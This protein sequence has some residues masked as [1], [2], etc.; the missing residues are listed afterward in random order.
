MEEAVLAARENAAQNN[1]TNTVFE[2]GDMRHCFN[3]D[4]IAR[5]GKADVVVTDPP[6][7]GCTL[8]SSPSSCNWHPRKLYM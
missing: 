4:F 2:S 7:M 6:E 8:K 3:A 5:H 1:I